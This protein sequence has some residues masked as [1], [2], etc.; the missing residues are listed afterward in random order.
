[1]SL[2]EP[3]DRM[4]IPGWRL[5]SAAER[6]FAG[7][8]S[9]PHADVEG[10]HRIGPRATEDDVLFYSANLST[11]RRAD[12]EV[13]WLYRAEF[14][15]PALE[16]KA[17]IYINGHMAVSDVSQNGS[18]V[19]AGANA[20]VI[21]AQ[22]TEYTRDLA[23]SFNDWNPAPPDSGMGVWRPVEL[24]L[25]GPVALSPLRVV[26]RLDLSGMDSLN[27]AEVSLSAAVTNSQNVAQ[28]VT[29][30]GEIRIPDSTEVIKLSSQVEMEKLAT[31][32]IA[33]DTTLTGRQ[34]QLWWP[35]TWG[36]QPLYEAR[37]FVDDPA[38]NL[39]D[40]TAARKF[41]LR[42][43]IVNGRP[44]QVRGA[45][46]RVETILRYALDVGLNTIRL[47]GKLEQPELYDMADRMGL[48]IMAGW[49][50]CDKWEA[51]DYNEDRSGDPWSYDDYQ[52]AKKSMSHEAEMM[53]NHPCLLAFLIANYM[54]VL[55]LSGWHNPIVASASNRGP[56][57]SGMKMEGPYDWVPPNYWYGAQYGAA[58]GFGSEL[59]AGVGTPGVR[60]LEKFMSDPEI[61]ALWSMEDTGHYHSAPEGTPFYTRTNYNNALISRYGRPKSL[62]EYVRKA[63]MM[64]YE[65]T[66]A[67]FEAYSV[68]QSATRPATG[69]IYWMLNQAWPSIHWQLFDYYLQPLGAY[70]GAKLGARQEHVALDYATNT[71]YLIN[72]SLNSNG[73]RHIAVD[74]VGMDGNS[75]LSLRDPVETTPLTSK[76][77]L[78]VPEIAELE[79]VAFLRL[80]LSDESETILSRNVY[81]LSPKTD[82]LDWDATT[83]YITPVTSYADF[84]ALDSLSPA[85]VEATRVA[86]T[87][88]EALATTAD[89]EVTLVNQGDVPAFFIRLIVSGPDSLEV[90]PVYYLFPAANTLSSSSLRKP[91]IMAYTGVSDIVGS[92][93]LDLTPYE[94]LYKHFHA[95]P[96]LS[97]QEQK[98]SEKVAAHLA[99]LNAYEIQTNIGGYGLVG[100]LKNGPGKTV[101]LRADIDAL[102]VK[103]LTSLPYASTVTMRDADGIEKPVM[104]ACGHDMHITCLLAA[105]EKLANLRD[106]WSGTLI[107]LFQPNEERGG[108]AQAMVND[109]L[110]DKIPVPDVALG[111]HV[112]RLRA[113]SIGCRTGTIMAAADSMKIT[114]FGRGGHGSLPHMTV[115]PVLLAAHIVVRLQGIVSREVDPSDLGVLT[116][117]SL[118]A[119]QTEN[120]IADR[121]EIG[122]DFRSVKLE[123]R[124]LIIDAVKRIVE[125]ECMASGSPKP[126]IFTPTRRF[127]PTV[128]EDTVAGQLAVSFGEHF[129]DAFDGDTP[130]TN[131]SEDFS[132]LATSRNVP[133]CFWFLGGIE[134][135]VWDEA[136]RKGTTAEVATNH[137]ALFAPAIQPTLAAGVD[138]LCVGALTFLRK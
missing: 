10:S 68:R 78:T 87:Y 13:S 77:I 62:D 6:G 32:R 2:Q 31:T 47:E 126:P 89:F 54:S 101:L 14:T 97:L 61:Q 69:V 127:P 117:G 63:Q 74:L 29:V 38:G 90:A 80:M 48:M 60:S 91:L 71:V 36:T 59:G 44:F 35:A 100:V 125:A 9:L 131:V 130:R 26:T 5:Q 134:Q 12:F 22:P 33:L 86:A 51:W 132:T 19:Q 24:S 118:Q 1:M 53:H 55:L 114:V 133:C 98:T 75:L 111:Q 39:S 8:W 4:V 104:H 56:V 94:D 110:Y 99:A 21:E 124:E 17:K 15:L 57:A 3:G 28:V 121:A 49:E 135:S 30:R 116:V 20:L 43:F 115:D 73:T 103:E 137:S 16:N 88:G 119:G 108:G 122:I 85:K 92:T 66:R 46:Q 42:T 52:V 106:Q 76:E 96:E 58:F 79:T 11:L 123:T 67:Q 50:C 82:V 23:I 128:N 34:I 65:A 93:S 105:A 27:A 136:E 138:A 95:N 129:G 18:F 102:P 83:W 107:V 25:A 70:Y 41:G 84:T 72:H 45:G 113:G 81:W 7:P 109:G 64:D 120:I 37:L 40:A 112:M